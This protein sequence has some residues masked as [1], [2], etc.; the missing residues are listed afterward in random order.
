MSA[1]PGSVRFGLQLRGFVNKTNKNIDNVRRGVALRL[2]KAIILDTP[3]LTGRLRANWRCSIDEPD[4][5]TT[6]SVDRTGASS[7]N[8]AA[9]I[10]ASSGMLDT[11]ILTNSLPYAA[12]IEY[13]GWSHTKAPEGMVRLNVARFE[14]L[15]GE[16]VS[17]TL[18]GG[19]I[20]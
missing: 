7:I 14:E 9:R 2:F 8:E 10:I 12:R 5:T 13:D 11:V 18:S 19:T 20:E 1:R 6:S 15:L 16:M 4:T 17:V 3:V